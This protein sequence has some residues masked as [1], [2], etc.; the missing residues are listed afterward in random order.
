MPKVGSGVRKWSWQQLK[1]LR[2]RGTAQLSP[3]LIMADVRLQ[4]EHGRPQAQ[5]QKK[6]EA[7]KE[8]L[9]EQSE[10]GHSWQCLPRGKHTHSGVPTWDCSYCA[11]LPDL[12]PP[13]PSTSLGTFHSPNSPVSPTTSPRL[14]H[15][16]FDW[17]LQG[18]FAR[19]LTHMTEGLSSLLVVGRRPTFLI[20]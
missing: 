5:Y 6:E 2:V 1:S 11:L 3:T 19:Q 8:R 13:C 14:H 4:G 9:V 15:L 7:G 16:S 20:R 10:G 17:L 12:L 18:L